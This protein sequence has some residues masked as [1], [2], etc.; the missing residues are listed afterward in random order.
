MIRVLQ[1]NPAMDRIEVLARFDLDAVNRSVEVH[2]MPGGKGLNVARGIRQLGGE[3]TA[4]GFAGGFVGAFLRDACWTLGIGDRHTSIAGETRICTIL[5]ERET[6]RCTVLNEPGP[7]IAPNEASAL[8]AALV[9]DC[10]RGDIVVLSGSLPRGVPDAFYAELIG[11]VQVAGAR[12]IVDTAGPPL[13]ESMVR[14]PWMV[15]L[16]LRELRE[17]LGT[18]LDEADSPAIVGAMRAQLDRGSAVVVVTLGAAGLFAATAGEVWRVTVPRIAALNAIGSGDLFL[19]GFTTV[20]SSGGGIEEGL[21]LGA[22]CG[23]ANAMSVTPE[24][25]ASIDV[26]ELASQVR[27]ERLEPGL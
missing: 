27:L 25:P 21:R 11:S 17:A 18:E 5:V 14:G 15:K 26:R 12:A 9:A 22:A 3:V 6:S 23:V 19:S 24:L 7:E 13:R 2:V 4:Y 16:N 10:R 20:L 8:V 1:A